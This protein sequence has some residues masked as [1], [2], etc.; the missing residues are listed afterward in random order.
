M[1]K[2]SLKMNL[3]HLEYIKISILYILN[4]EGSIGNLKHWNLTLIFDKS[5]F[6]I[7]PRKHFFIFIHIFSSQ[8]IFILIYFCLT[9]KINKKV[10]GHYQENISSRS[11][12]LKI[13][14]GNR[15]GTVVPR[16]HYF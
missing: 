11:E 1:F 13:S 14:L 5:L 16:K 7:V 10:G 3:K 4:D 12:H 6:Q 8:L 9:S 15:F 2:K